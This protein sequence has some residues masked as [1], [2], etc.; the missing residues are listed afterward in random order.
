MSVLGNTIK[1]DVNMA[2]E[3]I[4]SF[5]KNYLSLS[6]YDATGVSSNI[7]SMPN[8]ATRNLARG[9]A[10]YLS[11]EVEE[12]IMTGNSNLREM[13]VK[14]LVDDTLFETMK[15]VALENLVETADDFIG[16]LVPSGLNRD[17]IVS[18][19]LLTF[20]DSLGKKIGID[21]PIKNLGSLIGL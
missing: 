8:M 3:I 1:T 19:A 10:F 7:N 17:R 16:G 20:G 4:R 2:E 5:V 11:N 13:N 18:S 12:D 6:V 21:H 14:V 9:F 15:S